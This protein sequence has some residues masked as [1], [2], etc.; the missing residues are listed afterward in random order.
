MPKI[1]PTIKYTSRDFSSIRKD[2]LEYTK[3]YYPETYKD[4]SEAS[5]G[6]LMID[7]VSYVGDILSFYLDYQANETF[8]DSAVEFN[9]VLRLGRQMGYK[10][11][12]SNASFGELSCYVVVPATAE[13]LGPDTN[14]IPILRRGSVFASNEG[15]IFTLMED[16]DFSLAE[17]E[18]IVATVNQTTGNPIDYAIKAFGRIKSG[19]VMATTRQ[20]GN[21]E[22]FRKISLPGSNI[23]EVISVFD[24]EGREYFEVD[25]LSQN[26]VYREYLNPNDDS[27]LV[28]KVMKPV[29]VPRR[30]TTLLERNNTFLQFGYGSESTLTDNPLVDPADVILDVH[31]RD[32]IGDLSFDPSKLNET[33][34]L[35]VTPSNTTLRIVYRRNSAADA[36]ASAGTIVQAVDPKF[37]FKNRPL[38]TTGKVNKVVASL[39]VENE[40]PIT[41]D[42]SIPTVEELKT[43]IYDVHAAQNRSVTRDDYK[44]LV[45]MMPAKFGAIKRCNILQDKNSF[46]RNLNLYIISNLRNGQL[47]PATNTLKENLKIWINKNRM[48]NDTI[49][50][51][52]ANIINLGIDFEII[53]NINS[54]KHVVL[55]NAIAALRDLF[56]VKMDI[57]EN[58]IIS[59]IYNALNKVP[60]VSDTTD[61]D[62]KNITLAGYSS[63]PYNIKRFTSA[64]DRV[65]FCPENAIFE[66]KHPSK[67]LKGAVR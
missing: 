4:F 44:A 62:V 8:L 55:R 61:V 59:D 27:S 17:N 15:N 1:K 25:Y 35:G 3:R 51:L 19:E 11:K 42:V 65:L 12:R 47:T 24:S 14:Y 34:K 63:V 40:N 45:Y 26:V 32:Y 31:G 13:G 36:N 58:L 2:L 52:D 20:V 53:A 28:P 38:L 48:I 16:I 9:N 39:E 6:S 22:K 56:T 10:Y 64:D 66:L 60:G 23:T 50:I 37:R 57:G 7:T 43:R 67:D 49:D 30:F 41:G 18:T 54:N 46:K 33:D 29:I 21:Y 5:F